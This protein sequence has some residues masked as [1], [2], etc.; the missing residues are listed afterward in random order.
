MLRLR[1]VGL[2]AAARRKRSGRFRPTA[3]AGFQTAPHPRGTDHARSPR[4]LPRGT[5]LGQFRLQ[6]HHADIPT[7]D[8]RTGIRR[9]HRSAHGGA[10]FGSRQRPGADDGGKHS[11]QRHVRPFHRVVGKI[12]LRPEFPPAQRGTLYPR[13]AIPHGFAAPGFTQQTP[14]PLPV[15]TGT[16]EP[17]RRYRGGLLLHIRIR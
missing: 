1:P 2:S 3:P 15:G 17:S 5:L 14:P 16:Q 10:D 4:G 12:P 6:G 9:F 8:H 13:T 7:R 11:Q